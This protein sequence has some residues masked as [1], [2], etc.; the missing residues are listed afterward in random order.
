MRAVT[1]LVRSAVSVGPH[2]VLDG[3]VT[4]NASLPARLPRTHCALSSPPRPQL[5]S[6]QRLGRRPAA[7]ALIGPRGVPAR[8]TGPGHAA[9]SDHVVPAATR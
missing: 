1:H 9:R 7:G 8:L 3:K 2:Q 6:P 5:S 4:V